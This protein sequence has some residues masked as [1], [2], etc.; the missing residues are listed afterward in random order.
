MRHIVARAGLSPT[1]HDGKALLHILDTFPRDELF[2]GSE[3]ELFETAIG[4]LNLQERQRIALFVRRDPLERFV[5]CLVYV[6]RERYDSALRRRFAAILEE[7]FAGRIADLLHPSRR[8]GAG[9]RPVHHPH[10][11]RRCA[12]GRCRGAR[13]ATGRGRAQLVDRLQEAAEAAFG[14]AEAQ[15]RLR[16]LKPFRSPTRRCTE[17]AQAIADL[18]ADRERC[19]PARRSRSRCTRSP[20]AAARGCGSIAA[21]SRSSC[22]T[23]C[24]CWKI[25]GCASS[26]RSRSASTPSTAPRCGCTSSSSPARLPRP[27]CPPRCGGRFEEALVAVWTGRDR[28]RRLQPPGAGRRPS[29][30]PGRRSCGSTARCCARPAARSARPIWKTRWPRIP[31]SPRRLVR[32][33]EIRF[34]PARAAAERRA[35]RRRRGAG[36]RARARSRSRAS[37]RT[38]SCAAF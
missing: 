38:A 37:T 36:D 5:S 17:P 19:W 33:F 20:A 18:A 27:R 8:F 26:P 23:C 24:R 28:E 3:D 30:P 6:P 15:V 1:G 12:G 14:E 11:P 25:S 29:R 7:A 31:R 4:I 2:Q 35:R 10:H 22:R 21:P 13:T 32:L 34:D 9:P 16:R